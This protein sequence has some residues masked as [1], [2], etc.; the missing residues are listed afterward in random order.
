VLV[1]L[2]NRGLGPEEIEGL[3][4]EDLAG[5]VRRANGAGALTCT[6]FGAIPALP[7]REELERFLKEH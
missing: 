1:D 7:T 5:M 3:S 2:V 6:K 4:Q